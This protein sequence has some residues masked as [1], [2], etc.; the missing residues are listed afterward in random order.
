MIFG[1]VSKPLVAW[2]CS[3]AVVSFKLSPISPLVVVF[4]KAVRFPKTRIP[5][6]L[7]VSVAR[8]LMVTLVSMIVRMAVVPFLP[9]VGRMAVVTLLPVVGRMAVI[10]FIPV[11][12]IWPSI[13]STITIAK[14]IGRPAYAE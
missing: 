11:I 1:A 7:A 3:K 13:P 12:V 4:S 14:M 2:M 5:P 10:T 8:V 6:V 9:V